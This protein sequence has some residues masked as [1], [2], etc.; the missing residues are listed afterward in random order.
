VR[1]AFVDYELGV[2]DEFWMTGKE[3]GVAA[4]MIS[5]K[6]VGR[7]KFDWPLIGLL[8]LALLVRVATIIAFPSLHHPDENFQLF[9]QGHRWF[10][11]YGLVPWEFR[12][13]T[14]SPVMPFLLGLTFAAAE[15][16]AGGPEG[17]LFIT[18]LLLA[19]SSLAGV[20]AVYRMGQR[21]SPTHAFLGGLV[22]ATW[23]ELVYFA[24]RPLTEAVATTVLLIGLSIASVSEDD[25]TPKRLISIGL[26]FALCLMLRVHLALGILTAVV[27]VGRLHFERWWWLAVGALA[28]VV[29]FGI[30]DTIA[31]GGL[32]HSYIE[33]TRR[34]LLQGFASKCCG[35]QPF[36]WY[37]YRLIA[38]WSYA[39]PLFL[40]LIL[41]RT[42]SSM[43]W[44]LVALS[45]LLSHSF[46]PHKEYRFVF[47]ASACLIV[48]AAMGS[49]D[50][51]ESLR[52]RQSRRPVAAWP[53]IFATGAIWVIV[54]PA[55]AFTSKYHF[56]WFQKRDLIEAEFLLAKEPRLCGILIYDYPWWET[57]GYAYLHRN[58][59][60]YALDEHGAE[61]AAKVA[62]AFNAVLLKRSSTPDFPKAF[63][64]RKCM[65]SGKANDVCVMMRDGD[66]TRI[67]KLPQL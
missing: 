33:A 11:G 19:L 63:S 9:E 14:R 28:P 61:N 8:L 42:R 4:S 23:Y 64:I 6:E 67:P 12:V 66:C 27:W 46:V 30:A 31:W 47:P 44:V 41:L 38:G 53:M 1:R 43:L 25:F 16:I 48:V 35:T 3:G 2:L 29:V 22:T 18:K 65:G 39:A 60:F 17:Y 20:V 51:I 15:P 5:A 55:I 37:F 59:P 50:L 54:S 49:A 52:A 34:N 32:F 24:A 26:C 58:V 7:I 62:R 57:G 10:F 40:L 13:G 45:I 21:T 56:E 36:G